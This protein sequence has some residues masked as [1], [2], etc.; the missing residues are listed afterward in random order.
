MFKSDKYIT[1]GI[2]SEVPAWMQEFMWQTIDRMDVSAKDYLQ[3]FRLTQ[4]DRSGV[5]VQRV[6]HSQEDPLYKK[7]YFFPELADII[8]A[9]VFVIDD[10]T[11][12]T[13]L[14]AEEY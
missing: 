5:S 10:S 8:E 6:V 13:M 4:S 7:E 3:V 12:C 9:K 2:Q 14:L 1:K 11:H